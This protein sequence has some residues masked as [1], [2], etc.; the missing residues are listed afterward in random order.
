MGT[1]I[2]GREGSLEAGEIQA[3]GENLGSKG[4]SSDGTSAFFRGDA[5]TQAGGFDGV[6]GVVD[7]GNATNGGDT[8]EI[9]PSVEVAAGKNGFLQAGSEK[10]A[11]VTEHGEDGGDEEGGGNQSTAAIM[12]G[13]RLDRANASVEQSPARHI[14]L[15]SLDS[16]SSDDIE[17]IGEGSEAEKKYGGREGEEEKRE[18]RRAAAAAAVSAGAEFDEPVEGSKRVPAKPAAAEAEAADTAAPVVAAAS[19]G[20]TAGTLRPPPITTSVTPS[21]LRDPPSEMV[22]GK[23]INGDDGGKVS[24]E[25][26]DP[27]KMRACFVAKTFS[28]S[29]LGLGLVPGAGDGG[30]G[31]A[32]EAITKASLMK[33]GRRRRTIN[34]NGT[35]GINGHRG[36]VDEVLGLEDEPGSVPPERLFAV[37]GMFHPEAPVKVCICPFS[38]FR[39]TTQSVNI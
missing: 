14:S 6:Q 9:K 32:H 12:T 18:A 33:N 17:S 1:S 29:D 25:D 31:V 4:E 37:T 5:S 2:D 30:D 36:S 15:P 39:E 22:V 11:S 35:V 19:R 27:E 24:S 38:L 23:G 16:S 13:D 10:L 8:V 26:G 20:R 3:S 21:T 28:P 34:N 7:K